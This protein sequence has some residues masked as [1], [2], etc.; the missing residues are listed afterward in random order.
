M[1]WRGVLGYLPVN[2][3]QGVVGLLTIV[4]FT[5]VLDPRQY[6]D[7]ALALSVVMVVHTALFTWLEAAMARFQ[8]A[9]A[10][11]GS[12]ANH[13]ATLYR[14]W[15]MLAAAL[16]VVGGGALALWP[17]AASLKIALATG[18]GGTLFKGLGRLAQ[19]HR[20]A[21]GRVKE[22]ALLDIVI[23]AGG[24]AAGALLAVA[25]LGGAAPLTGLGLAFMVCLVWVLPSELKLARGGRLELARIK[26]YAHYGLPLAASL[27]LGLILGTVD[28]FLIAA[29]MDA[30]AVGVY[31]A[32]YSLANR[33]LDVIFIWLGSAA[34]PA[35]IAA[36][37][38]G[39]RP[40]LDKTAREQSS[41]MLLVTIPA[42]VGLALVAKPLAGLLV[43]E[44][45]RDGAARVT[46]WIAASG[47]FAGITT[48]YFH[49]AFTLAKATRLMLLAMTVPA[50][51]NI[52]LN[53]L[54]IPRFGLTGA[55]IATT[56]S[57]GLGLVASAAIGR[58]A[59]A[60]PI[61]WD[62]LI[63]AGLASAV[64]A[65]AVSLIPDFGG[66]LELALKAGVGALVYG[67][68]ALV[69]DAGGA[70]SQ[71]AALVSRLRARVSP[72]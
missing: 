8:P 45:L 66:L 49:T 72:A 70:R 25:G 34:G 30:S 56:V 47:L 9:E 23:T 64:M 3:V 68:L 55:V 63:R 2:I 1:F 50:A 40:A 17:M 26:T 42:A 5:R 43:G 60:L 46:P 13:F 61:P 24:F 32:G 48:Y 52:V 7:Y 57:Y 6:G 38:F 62:T 65:V 67:A 39:G 31:H 54:L 53:V 15:G 22:A 51:A 11:T 35:A 29:F 71:G 44:A 19:E 33:T 10:A 20:R 18:L 69:L 37:E 21:A 58:R 4:V 12:V 14:T 41:F 27:I 36:L 16:V 59:I 28:R